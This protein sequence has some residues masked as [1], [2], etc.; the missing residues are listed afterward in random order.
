MS[1]QLVKLHENGLGDEIKKYMNNLNEIN[2]IRRCVENSVHATNIYKTVA[3][4]EDANISDSSEVPVGSEKHK[5]NFLLSAAITKL[6]PIVKD[7]LKLAGVAAKRWNEQVGNVNQEARLNAMVAK[8]KTPVKE[9]PIPSYNSLTDD[10]RDL[11]KDIFQQ[12]LKKQEPLSIDF[13]TEAIDR[14]NAGADRGVMF[15]KLGLVIDKSTSIQQHTE[16]AF[17]ELTTDDMF[18]YLITRWES[19]QSMVT[20][21]GAAKSFTAASLSDIVGKARFS[22]SAVF[23][24]IIKE[25][26][27]GV[28]F[29]KTIDDYKQ[30]EKPT[31]TYADLKPYLNDTSILQT[32]SVN[33]SNRMDALCRVVSQLKDVPFYEIDDNNT[34]ME[35]DET[36]SSLAVYFEVIDEITQNLVVFIYL[37]QIVTRNTTVMKD[38]ISVINEVDVVLSDLFNKLSDATGGNTNVSQESFKVI[39]NKILGREPKEVDV[40]NNEALVNYNAV[41]NLANNYLEI[42]DTL[43]RLKLKDNHSLN[44]NIANIFIAKHKDVIKST[45]GVDISKMDY[46]KLFRF[47]TSDI[48]TSTLSTTAAKPFTADIFTATDKVSV[49]MRRFLADNDDVLRLLNTPLTPIKYGFSNSALDLIRHYSRISATTENNYDQTKAKQEI[50]DVLESLA[51]HL[52]GSYF[53]LSDD[54]IE[55]FPLLSFDRVPAVKYASVLNREDR[56]I[57]YRMINAVSQQKLYKTFIPNSSNNIT[58]NLIKNNIDI[59][60][61]CKN[62]YQYKQLTLASAD[63]NLDKQIGRLELERM[64]KFIQNTLPSV[65]ASFVKN[66]HITKEEAK[67]YGVGITAMAADLENAIA[68]IKARDKLSNVIHSLGSETL[69]NLR[70][71]YTDFNVIAEDFINIAK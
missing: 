19:Y 8:L 48:F 28:D 4:F 25:A 68:D 66:P 62:A 9:Q 17:D 32:L 52:D 31:T 39:I 60:N 20:A 1:K 47:M 56:Y 34:D 43:F 36:Y 30:S 38:I 70:G 50:E 55:V 69:K 24:N 3:S 45:Y 6:A 71:L 67:Q 44:D 42:S 61:I 5:M 12:V 58:L 35:A 26:T 63:Y 22:K 59:F 10:Q 11:V 41:V 29:S 15:D 27:R 40:D 46:N 23:D 33:V 57:G 18:S 7:N 14:Y 37:T 21:I 13:I 16:K 51:E 53:H 64:Y 54:W 2:S 49:A 65:T